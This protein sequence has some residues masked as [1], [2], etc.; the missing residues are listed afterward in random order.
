MSS[1]QRRAFRSLE[2]LRRDAA[3]RAAD[4]AKPEADKGKELADSPLFARIKQD[5]CVSMR[6]LW[7]NLH[8]LYPKLGRGL[9]NAVPCRH[10]SVIYTKNAKI[11]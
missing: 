8:S 3:R 5:L 4:M 9:R 10:V 1:D 2:D 7:H 11:G 6:T